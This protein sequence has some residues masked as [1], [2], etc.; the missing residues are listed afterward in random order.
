MSVSELPWAGSRAGEPATRGEPTAYQ[1]FIDGLRAW[2][3]LSVMLYHLDARWLPGGFS[4]VD[5]FFR[6]FRFRRERVGRGPRADAVRAISFVFLRAARAADSARARRGP[7][8]DRADLGA[9]HSGG[10]PERP[11]PDDRAARVL[12]LEQRDPRRA[13]RRLFF[14]EGGVQ[15]VHAYVVAR[16][17]G[18]VLSAVPAAVLG[19]ARGR[20]APACVERAVRGGA[21]R[22]AGMD[23]LGRPREACASVLPDLRALLGARVGRAA[24]SVRRALRPLGG[25]AGGAVGGGLRDRSGRVGVGG[26]GA[27]R[28]RRIETGALS[29]SRRDRARRRHAGTA[30]PAVRARACGPDPRAA[31]ASGAAVRRQDFVFALSVA[32]AG[33]RRV[34]LDGRARFGGQQGERAARRGRAGDGVIPLRRGAVAARR[35]G[36]LRRARGG[37]RALRRRARRSRP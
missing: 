36:A 6:D 30:R 24:V 29:V 11:E 31:R 34:P 21:W 12:R 17:R 4:G 25:Q 26:C 18:A 23:R 7:A 14:A 13:G 3:V 27:G 28:I 1:P 15:S 8:R 20:E 16:R 2:A 22:V 33:V 35:G 37:E 9:F 10:L 19:V 5:I 32:L